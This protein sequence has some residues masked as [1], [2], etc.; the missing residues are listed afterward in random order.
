MNKEK[1]K[2]SISTSDIV[3]TIMEKHDIHNGYYILLPELTVNV[4]PHAVTS[5]DEQQSEQHIGITTITTGYSLIEAPDDLKKNGWDASAINPRS[6][7][8]DESTEADKS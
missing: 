2:Y 7:K 6:Q 8:S 4:G 5:D 3:K 1:T